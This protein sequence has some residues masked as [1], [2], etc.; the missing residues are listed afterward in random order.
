LVSCIVCGNKKN[1]DT[2]QSKYSDEEFIFI[3][4]IYY[5]V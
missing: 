2:N 3:H 4:A 5:N 1:E